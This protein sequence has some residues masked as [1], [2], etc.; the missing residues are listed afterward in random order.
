MTAPLFFVIDQRTAAS[1]A[2]SVWKALQVRARHR[3]LAYEFEPAVTRYVATSAV[4]QA[5]RAGARTIA[6]V[7]SDAL[8]SEAV[9]GFFLD[10]APIAEDA[11][12]LAIPVEPATAFAT[13]LGIRTAE[14]ALDLLQRGRARHLD[15]AVA[16]FL[17]TEGRPTTR[18]FVN[19][20]LVGGEG[21]PA[22]GPP[23]FGPLGWT[24]RLRADADPELVVYAKSMVL[25]L[26]PGQSGPLQAPRAK[27]DD[28]LLD[29]VVEDPSTGLPKDLA[30][31]GARGD[32]P[33]ARA[34][35]IVLDMDGAP[36]I[37]LDGERVGAGSLEARVLPGALT[38]YVGG[39]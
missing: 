35:H 13:N 10:D 20:A 8:I 23:D 26:G 39:P 34:R 25:A 5:L 6:V 24:G 27:M 32:E 16:S 18:I 19:G 7:G 31:P 36:P 2:R 22:G 4:R 38:A 30:P 17:D 15:L 9:N 11:V 29:V 1:R 28:G 33:I 14:G 21:M 12:L 3:G 37:V